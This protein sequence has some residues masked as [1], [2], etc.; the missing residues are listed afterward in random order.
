MS[1]KNLAMDGTY[2]E[3]GGAALCLQKLINTICFVDLT[4]EE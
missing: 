3:R 2:P 4:I 1:Y